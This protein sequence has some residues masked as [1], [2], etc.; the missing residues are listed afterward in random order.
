MELDTDGYVLKNL[1]E[2]EFLRNA[3][4]TGEQILDHNVYTFNK[5]SRNFWRE[6]GITMQTNPLELNKAELREI[7]AGDCVQVIYGR[8]PMMTTAG[9]LHK[10]L[11][12]CAKKPGQWTL[13]D[14]YQKEFPVKNYCRD[15]YNIIYN[16]QPLY[17]LD[18]MDGLLSLEVG[19]YR[20]M[21][22]TEGPGE[23]KNILECW[24]SGERPK[25]EFTRG[26]FKRGVE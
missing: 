16:S 2:Y 15:C 24:L 26:H 5:R 14:R 21:F 25:G 18:Q 6:A 7:S 1:E 8:Y 22:T 11:N 12:Q 17:L 9:C 3:G 13:K 19:A 23:V 10:T 20:M 4:W